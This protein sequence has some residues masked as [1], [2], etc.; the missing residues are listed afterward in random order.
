MSDTRTTPTGNAAR[1]GNLLPQRFR[2]WLPLMFF[3]VFVV[4]VMLAG[5]SAFLRYKQKI[6]RETQEQLSGIAQLK[7]MQITSWIAE[8]KGNAQTI[9]DDPLFLS[10]A[11]RWLNQGA[12]AGTMRTELLER[13]QLL[14][15]SAALYGCNAI[16]LFD[17]GAKQRLSA[18]RELPS[19]HDIALLRDSIG[20]KEIRFSDVHSVTQGSGER[21]ELDF[22][23]PL[24]AGLGARKHA[25]GA[26][27]LHFNAQSFL[28]PLIQSWPTRSPSA[29]SLLVRREGDTVV[30]LN[31]L[32]HANNAP[33]SL[34]MP[35]TDTRLPA[36]MAALGQ[37]GMVEGIDYRGVPVVGVLN[38]IPGTQWKMVSKVDQAEIYAPVD[39]L[40]K[41]IQVLMLGFVIA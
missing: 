21:F 4:A 2:Q 40:S 13:L 19:A 23:V 16:A 26:V 22:A 28:F 29:E 41:W 38:R 35:L 1:H 36:A 32:R 34:R 27:L 24:I 7:T 8:R 9:K 5:N 17:T 33:L 6:K 15:R 18:G 31:E 37:E 14:Q 30:F 3:G 10:E 12:P 11:A 39:S 25:I 20:S